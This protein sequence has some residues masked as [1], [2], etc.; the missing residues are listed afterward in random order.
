MI[1]RKDTL[2]N[3]GQIYKLNWE[4]EGDFKL[5][6]GFGSL[7]PIFQDGC[8]SMESLAGGGVACQ[9]G[10]IFVLCQTQ[11]KPLF[12]L[13]QE[14]LCHQRCQWILWTKKH[15]E[16]KGEFFVH[17]LLTL[18]QLILKPYLQTQNTV[19]IPSLPLQPMLWVSSYK[20]ISTAIATFLTE[21]T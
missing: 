11:N 4:M 5:Y 21:V 13:S 19:P 18:L 1:V 6:S 2:K 15:F 12:F 10:E 17:D 9:G 14:Q 16:C 7:V 3:L 8:W 20:T